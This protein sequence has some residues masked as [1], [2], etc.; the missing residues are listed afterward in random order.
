MVYERVSSVKFE[1]SNENQK[2]TVFPL[3][4]RHHLSV[5]FL[6]KKK[7]EKENKSCNIWK[8]TWIFLWRNKLNTFT[9]RKIKKKRIKT[10]NTQDL[11]Q[12]IT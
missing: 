8:F 5:F 2:P 7:K 11:N 4:H 10:K 6:Y 3:R 9:I 12:I 1:F